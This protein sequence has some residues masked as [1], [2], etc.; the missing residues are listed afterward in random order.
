MHEDGTTPH[1]QRLEN[2]FQQGIGKLV[3]AIDVSVKLEGMHKDITYMRAEFVEFKK[4][5]VTQD[6]FAPYQSIMKAMIGFILLSFMG[7]I[8]ALILR[9]G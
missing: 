3:D 1:Q 2:L 5:I 6:Q 4:N 9:V 8:A 7:G